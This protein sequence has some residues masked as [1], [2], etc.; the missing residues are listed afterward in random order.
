MKLIVMTLAA[1]ALKCI[2]NKYMETLNI[3]NEYK[4]SAS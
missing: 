2:Q 1:L 4:T 3:Y